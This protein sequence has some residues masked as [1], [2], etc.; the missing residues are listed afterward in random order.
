MDRETRD[1]ICGIISGQ[2]RIN[3]I[4]IDC[5]DNAGLLSKGE[6]AKSL[7]AHAEKSEKAPDSP[8]L[9]VRSDLIIMRHLAELLQGDSRPDLSL[10][11]GGKPDK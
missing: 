8:K 2:C 9:K 3:S 7:S 6:L 4:I 11:I 5:L 10:I 1:Y